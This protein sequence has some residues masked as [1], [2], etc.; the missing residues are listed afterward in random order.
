MNASNLGDSE[1]DVSLGRE[2]SMIG[3]MIDDITSLGLNEPY[4]MFT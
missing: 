4:R 2:E 3:V 1:K